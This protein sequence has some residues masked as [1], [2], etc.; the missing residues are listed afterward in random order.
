M[1]PLLASAASIAAG[2][3]LVFAARADADG[4][5]PPFMRHPLMQMNVPAICLGLIVVGAAQ[6]LAT[7]LGA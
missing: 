5:P 2:L 7:V 3:S 1:I 4:V 6:I